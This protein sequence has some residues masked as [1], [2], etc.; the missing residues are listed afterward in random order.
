MIA[1]ALSESAFAAIYA[2]SSIAVIVFGILAFW[3]GRRLSKFTDKK[4]SANVLETAHANEGLAKANLEIEKQKHK[5]LQLQQELENE[6][7]GGAEVLT[8]LVPRN[9]QWSE[10]AGKFRGQ[11]KEFAGQKVVIEYLPEAEPR[12]A[13]NSLAQELREVGWDVEGPTPNE[14]LW[15]SWYKGVRLEPYRVPSIATFKSEED[16]DVYLQAQ[17]AS[18]D[19]RDCLKSFL[20]KRKWQGVKH[21]WQDEGE[22]PKG[23]LRIRIGTKQEPELPRNK[24]E[25]M[26]ETFEQDLIDRGFV[27]D[28]GPVPLQ[29]EVQRLVS[30]EQHDIVVG[31]LSLERQKYEEVQWMNMVPVE[32]R[33]PTD[34]DEAYQYAVQVAGLLTDSNWVLAGGEVRRDADIARKLRG[35]VVRSHAGD[36]QQHF[37][38]GDIMKAFQQAGIDARDVNDQTFEKLQILIGW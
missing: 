10:L 17:W 18:C 34:N 31:I 32:V 15:K 4:I 16:F 11:L 33:C 19:A 35:I 37:Q 6:K 24:W 12:R 8:A 22:L 21:G 1:F 14:E 28:E 38:C 13:G 25:D 27:K 36:S 26:D 2:V 9:L 3:S 7:Y 20:K 23:T 5:N 30:Q 29:R